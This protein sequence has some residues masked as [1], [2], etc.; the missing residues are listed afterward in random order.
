MKYRVYGIVKGG[1]YL[2]EFE[3]NSQEE[4]VEMG[5]N[6]DEA[7]VYLCHQC[8]GDCED[9]MIEEAYA[10]LDEPNNDKE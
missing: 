9:P 4:A 6:S 7:Q 5:L 2:G 10:E 8:S 1:K 3:A